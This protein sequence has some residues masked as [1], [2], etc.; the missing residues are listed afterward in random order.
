M[1]RP[2]ALFLGFAFVCALSGAPIAQETVTFPCD[3]FE[4]NADGLW[5][6]ARE[7]TFRGPNGQFTMRPGVSFRPDVTCS[8]MDM[9]AVLERL[10]SRSKQ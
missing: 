8:G 7:V 3:A 1:F 2:K 5:T 6:P 4:K 10:C 9:A